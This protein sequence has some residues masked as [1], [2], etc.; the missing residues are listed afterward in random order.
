MMIETGK[1]AVLLWLS[2]AGLS[3]VRAIAEVET[4]M[5][6][7][8]TTELEATPIT[9]SQ[10]HHYQI[11]TGRR[12]ECFGFFDTLVQHDYQIKETREGRDR[13][14]GDLIAL[15][16]SAGWTINYNEISPTNLVSSVQAWA[17]TATSFSCLIVKCT[18]TQAVTNDIA[19]NL[20][21]TIQLARSAVGDTGLIALLSDAQLAPV[22]QF[23]NINNY[24]NELSIIERRKADGRIDW[25]DSLAYFMGHGQLWVNLLGRDPQG[26]VQRQDEYE[27]V[28]DT[29]IQALPQRLR[30]PQTGQPVIAQVHRKEDLYSGDY[31]FCAPDLV[32]TFQPGYVPST[33]STQLA[34][35]KGI[36]TKPSTGTT[37]ID[38]A[39]P[40]SIRGF[41]IASAPALRQGATLTT[42]VPLTAV[43]PT[44]L[45]AL[46]VKYG[47]M[48]S[49]ALKECFEQKYLAAHPLRTVEQ[50]GLSGEEEELV[51]NRLRDLG[52]I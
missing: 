43:A 45:H 3:S 25:S 27:E 42:P 36:F 2:G 32:V 44:L 49:T 16:S 46:D 39:H 33:R 5:Q 11:T 37:A 6:Q 17:K 24:L 1:K 30:D 10:A 52:Y 19:A 28:R 22:K 9:G 7:G 21:Q 29:L 15:M 38:G 23:V 35:D 20:A 51:I 47:I 14:P 31:L 34:F 50:Q 48:D 18:L 26:I 8:I 12:P 41:L 13:L 40:A 4:L